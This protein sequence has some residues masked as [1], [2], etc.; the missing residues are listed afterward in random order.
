MAFA[1]LGCAAAQIG[2][3]HDGRLR[4]W[5]R[6]TKPFTTTLHTL[7]VTP[8]ALGVDLHVGTQHLPAVV[9]EQVVDRTGAGDAFCGFLAARLATNDDI[10]AAIQTATRAAALTVTRSGSASSIPTAAEIIATEA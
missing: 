9:V 6:S 1:S 8:G 7:I 5:P 2:L 10:V 3:S 4:D